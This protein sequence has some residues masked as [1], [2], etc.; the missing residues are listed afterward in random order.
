MTDQRLPEP[1]NSSTPSSKFHPS[2]IF[3]TIYGSSPFVHIHSSLKRIPRPILR[4]WQHHVLGAYGLYRHATVQERSCAGTEPH[5]QSSVNLARGHQYARDAVLRSTS[6]RLSTRVVV[7]TP[8]RTP[9]SQNSLVGGACVRTPLTAVRACAVGIG[10]KMDGKTTL[11]FP[12][13]RFIIGNGI[14]SGIVGNGNRIGINGIAKMNGNGNT[15][16]NS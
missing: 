8:C 9:P 14:R 2:N 12:C 6:A 1:A 7:A 15:N 16:G 3:P 13:P 4:T 5:L 10:M 11:P